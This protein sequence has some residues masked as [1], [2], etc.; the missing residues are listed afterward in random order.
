MDSFQKNTSSPA[1]LYAIHFQNPEPKYYAR[2]PNIIDHLTYEIEKDGVKETRRL[3]VYAK[4]LYRV[5][6]MIA[7]DYNKCWHSNE[8]LAEIMNCSTGSITNAKKE[9]LMPM[10][11]LEG[12][13]LILEKKGTTTR[14]LENG[15]AIQVPFSHKTLINIWPW[16]N[17]FMATRKYQKEYGRRDSCGDLPEPRDSCGDLP[18]LDRDS[19]GECNNNPCLLDPICNVQ[20]PTADADPVVFKSQKKEE[21]RRK[22]PLDK[23]AALKWMIFHKCHPIVALDFAKRFSC[24]DIEKAS[25]YVMKQKESTK[26]DNLWGYFR[27]V[28]EG[29][30]WLKKKFI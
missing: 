30:F 23:Q 5:L 25:D 14:K 4:E 17:A 18:L 8:S 20:Q 1:E 29:K 28:I 11:Q 27:T 2:V 16:N 19:P 3:S 6:R 13:P 7:S 12:S 9:L 10:K 22:L 26:I 15:D 24:D 21:E